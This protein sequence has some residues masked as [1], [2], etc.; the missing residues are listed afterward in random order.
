[1]FTNTTMHRI[2]LTFSS[3]SLMVM[4]HGIYAYSTEKTCT[5]QVQK[6]MVIYE[7]A[8]YMIM[9]EK[10]M[11]YNLKQSFWFNNDKRALILKWHK[12]KEGDKIRVNYYGIYVPTLNM[13]PNIV[14]LSNSIDEDDE[15][16]DDDRDYYP[17]D[18]WEDDDEV[19]WE[20][21]EDEEG[22]I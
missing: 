14:M 18:D 6:K 7:K 15:D 21:D 4:S 19:D 8:N 2:G 3:V 16:D 12:L 17:Y 13:Y 22:E 10:G 1:M 9:D 5:I 20:D 11:R